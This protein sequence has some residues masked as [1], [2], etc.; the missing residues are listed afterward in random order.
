[1]TKGFILPAL[2]G[3]L[4]ENTHGQEQDTMETRTGLGWS[5]VSGISAEDDRTCALVDMNCLGG[6]K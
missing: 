1:M 6:D 3:A 2:P 4:P 5:N